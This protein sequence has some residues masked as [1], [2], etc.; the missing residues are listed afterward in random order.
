M[1]DLPYKDRYGVKIFWDL[2]RRFQLH[3]E[4]KREG[5]ARLWDV[6]FHHYF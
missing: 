4:F 3:G 5:S 6:G 2:G 1:K